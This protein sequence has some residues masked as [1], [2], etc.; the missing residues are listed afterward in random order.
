MGTP[1]NSAEPGEIARTVLMP[2]DPFRGI[3]CKELA[4]GCKACKP[5]T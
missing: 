4:D 1:H 2:G 3:Y 5:D